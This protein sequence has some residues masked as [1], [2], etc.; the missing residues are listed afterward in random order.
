MNEPQKEFTFLCKYSDIKENTGNRF[1][2]NENDIAVFK[3]GGRIYALSNICPHQHSPIIYDGIIEEGNVV[4]PAHGWSFELKSGKLGGNRR[5]LEKYE[6][7]IA[8]NDVYIKIL[9]TKFQLF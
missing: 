7:M 1:F 6:V 9:D 4:C 2:I 5:G 8:G 3:V